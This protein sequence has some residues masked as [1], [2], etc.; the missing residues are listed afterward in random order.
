VLDRLTGQR[1]G[2]RIVWVEIRMGTEKAARSIS[3]PCRLVPLLDHVVK[4]EKEV[5][6]CTLVAG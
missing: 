1:S 5:Q 4:E 2:S 3:W 6:R